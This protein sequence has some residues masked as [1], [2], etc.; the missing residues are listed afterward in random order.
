MSDPYLELLIDEYA[1]TLDE[2][3]ERHFKQWD[4][5][6]QEKSSFG[7][8]W[9]NDLWY[10]AYRVSSYKDEIDTLK[11]WFSARLIFLD[12]NMPGTCVTTGSN[13]DEV[14]FNDLFIFPNPVTDVIDIESTG[15][16]KNIEVY[17]LSGN[18]L[19]SKETENQ[20]RIILN[21]FTG[22]S[23]VIAWILAKYC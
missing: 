7:G 8:L 22:F 20:I 4:E 11:G 13:T 12:N 10:S 2:A 9:N 3:Q 17:D 1:I 23:R 21:E 16:I 5:L 18:N 19:V 15:Q 14:D 6:L